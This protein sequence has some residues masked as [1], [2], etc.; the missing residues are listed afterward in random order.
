MLYYIM[1]TTICFRNN[2]VQISTAKFIHITNNN[3]LYLQ[4]TIVLILL[5]HIHFRIITVIIQVW[6]YDKILSAK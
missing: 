5:K 2:S 1:K 6:F 4:F 3:V